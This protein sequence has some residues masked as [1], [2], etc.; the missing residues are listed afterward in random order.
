MV[1]VAVGKNDLV[2]LIQIY[3]H[4]LCVSQEDIGIACIEQNA[5]IPVLQIETKRRFSQVVLIDECIVV[6]QNGQFHTCI[7][8]SREKE[9]SQIGTC[10]FT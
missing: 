2:Y 1:V 9:K 8:T 4:L 3:S 6:A 10:D 5:V 7:V